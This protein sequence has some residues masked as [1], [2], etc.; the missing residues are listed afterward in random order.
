MTERRS[1]T[2][3]WWLLVVGL[4]VAHFAFLMLGERLLNPVFHDRLSP[5]QLEPPWL[6]YAF[7]CVFAFPATLIF[8]ITKPGP[9][10]GVFGWSILIP[11]LILW[12]CV[13]A[14]PIR[15]RHGWRPWV[16]DLLIVTTTIAIILALLIWP[17]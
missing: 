15:R 9:K 4:A 3:K 5:S 7:I 14:E 8:W 1:G 11:T 2:W 10:D 6:Y 17:L 16:L 12:G 13:W